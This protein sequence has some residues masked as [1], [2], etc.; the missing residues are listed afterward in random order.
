M[1][2]MGIM[3]RAGALRMRPLAVC[4]AAACA[5]SLSLAEPGFAASSSPAH[6]G[7][8]P[9]PTALISAPPLHPAGV[10]TNCDDSGAGSLRDTVGA[11]ASG[12]LIDLSGLSCSHITLTTGAIVMGQHDIGFQ[13]PGRNKLAVDA[14]GSPGSSVFVHLGGGT[15]HIDGITIENGSK[16]TSDANAKGGCVYSNGNV[17]LEHSTVDHCSA[18]THLPYFS[19]GGG[20]YSGLGT[21]LLDT[22]VTNNV[23]SASNSYAN[24]GGVFA[25]GNLQT[26]YAQISNNTAV[27]ENSWG[28]GV[29][30]RGETLIMNTEISGNHANNRAGAAFANLASA[31]QTMI[32]STVSGNVAT[33]VVGGIDSLTALYMY[34][35][36]VAFNSAVVWNDGAG[37]YFGA[38]VNIAVVSTIYSSILSNNTVPGVGTPGDIFDLSGHAPGIAGG[39]DVIMEFNI[40]LPASVDHGDPGLGPL[41][42]NG[43]PT[44]TQRPTSFN[45]NYGDNVAN[46]INDQRGAGFPR[47]TTAGVTI[48]AYEHNPDVIFINGFN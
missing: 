3:G 7:A 6:A 38:G 29:F 39:D 22:R 28:G 4:L 24:A 46:L 25:Y 26:N 36:T 1:N 12:D 34:N 47:V 32:N 20:V 30:T 16:Y 5:V 11:A 44:H 45:T 2:T 18:S 15:L 10:V 48:G 8:R 23:S 41:Q 43:G 37:T 31:R 40:G 27:G 33:H 19:F 13:G 42:D 9:F 17:V 21:Y 14:S 35:C